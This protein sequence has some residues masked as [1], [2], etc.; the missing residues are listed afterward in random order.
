MKAGVPALTSRAT[1]EE[2]RT[3]RRS[4]LRQMEG[5]KRSDCVGKAEKTAAKPQT[6]L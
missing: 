4:M 1:V 3:A 5:W 6:V 2:A